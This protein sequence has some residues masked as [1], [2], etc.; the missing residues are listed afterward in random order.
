M[1]NLEVLVG[2]RG[3]GFAY[4]GGGIEGENTNDHIVE[5]LKKYTGIRYARKAITNHS[6]DV[7]ENLLQFKPTVYHLDFDKMMELGEEFIKLN[8]DV[9][10][11]YYIWGHSYELDYHDSWEKF[12]KFC[13]MMSGRDDIVYG[14][15]QEVLLR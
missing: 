14:T 12:E 9:P 8:T 4:P 15:N 1:E 3:R 6:F 13:K 11:I 10:K 5:V 2:K 7:Q